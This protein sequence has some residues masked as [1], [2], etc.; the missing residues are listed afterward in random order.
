MA[1]SEQQLCVASPYF[2]A[3]TDRYGSKVTGV[4]DFS[5]EFS[6]DVFIRVCLCFRVLCLRFYREN[7]WGGVMD[8]DYGSS[9]SLNMN[10]EVNFVCVMPIHL[11]RVRL[12][13]CS[14]IDVSSLDLV[15]HGCT[16]YGSSSS[17]MST[18]RLTVILFVSR[19]E[20]TLYPVIYCLECLWWP[21]RFVIN[22]RPSGV[23]IF[24]DFFKV[25]S[26]LSSSRPLH[27]LSINLTARSLLR[28]WCSLIIFLH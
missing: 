8:L 5:I 1:P 23:S 3:L 6:C 17:R 22:L 28:L 21:R 7:G 2:R 10:C 12:I 19:F 18:R 11:Y 27:R 24:D 25:F 15:I 14:C 13:Q 20:Y 9:S 4:Y 26:L 16:L